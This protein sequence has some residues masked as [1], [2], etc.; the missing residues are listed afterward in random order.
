MQ[1]AGQ[2]S[3]LQV[4]EDTVG[5]LMAALTLGFLAE[6]FCTP[7][8]QLTEHAPHAD[9]S[10]SHAMMH[11][12]VLQSAFSVR[13]GQWTPSCAASTTTVRTRCFTP[14]PHVLLHMFQFPQSETMQLTGQA[15]MLQF[16]FSAM[17]SDP[18]HTRPP[19]EAGLMTDRLRC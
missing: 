19:E 6:R 10:R 14:P 1:S 13:A 11:A 8:P 17:E 2:A 12:W 16:S 3:V 7:P 9:H 5:Q 15:R 18:G 4:R